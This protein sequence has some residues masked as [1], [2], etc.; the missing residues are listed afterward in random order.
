[1]ALLPQL[2]PRIRT[3][4]RRCGAYMFVVVAALL[5]ASA[6][7]GQTPIAFWEPPAWDIPDNLKASAPKE[8]VSSL[9][10]AGYEITL[11]ETKMDDVQQRLGGEIGSK[12]DA[13]DALEWLCFHGEDGTGEWVLW[14]ESGEI[15]GGLE[16]Q[17]PKSKRR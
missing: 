1:M 14:L 15:D 6:Q 7:S 11:E 4:N 13:G 10:V 8:M 16:H 9:S 2:S 5:Q 12:G 3:M 17:K